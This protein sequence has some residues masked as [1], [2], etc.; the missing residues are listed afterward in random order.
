MENDGRGSEA[1]I[2]QSDRAGSRRLHIKSLFRLLPTC[3]LCVLSLVP[4][5]VTQVSS[6]SLFD[7]SQGPNASSV[8]RLWLDPP[9]PTPIPAPEEDSLEEHMRQAMST[10]AE[11]L[12]WDFTVESGSYGPEQA[13]AE[14]IRTVK[15]D[16]VCTSEQGS[17]LYFDTISVQSVSTEAPTATEASYPFPFHGYIAT[18]EIIEGDPGTYAEIFR[19]SNGDGVWFQAESWSYCSQ[20]RSPME[21]DVMPMAEAI[22]EAAASVGLGQNVPEPEHALP[23][24]TKPLFLPASGF[25][26][27]GHIGGEPH[28]LSVTE[29]YAYVAAGP[30][31]SILEITPGGETQRIGYVVLPDI[32]EGILAAEDYVYVADGAAGVWLIDT[33]SPE[34]PR[35]IS[36]VRLPKQTRA[37]ALVK[38]RDSIY[39]ASDT[40]IHRIDASAAPYV[41]RHTTTFSSPHPIV[42][43]DIRGD[44]LF[45][46]HIRTQLDVVRPGIQVFSIEA[47]GELRRLAELDMEGYS[48][49]ATIIAIEDTLYAAAGSAGLVVLDVGDPTAPTP[50]IFWPSEPGTANIRNIFLHGNTL[51]A[52]DTMSGLVRFDVSDPT[53]PRILD[54]APL[55]A[56]PVAAA[57]DEGNAYILTEDGLEIISSTGQES[58]SFLL[59]AWADRV[60]CSDTEAFLADDDRILAVSLADPAEPVVTGSLAFPSKVWNITACGGEFSQTPDSLCAVTGDCQARDCTGQ[61][62]VVDISQPDTLQPQASVDTTGFGVA[63][64]AVEDMLYVAARHD[65]LWT[66]SLAPA[67]LLEPA[68]FL[69]TAEFARNVAVND[70]TVLIA[71]RKGGLRLIDISNPTHPVELGSTL[72]PDETWCAASSEAIAV[73]GT[74][75]FGLHTYDISNPN[76]IREMGVLDTPATVANLFLDPTSQQAYLAAWFDGLRRVDISD[77]SQ[78]SETG[79]LLTPGSADDVDSN[80]EIIC[81]ADS[82]GGLFLLRDRH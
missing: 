30:E 23:K 15:P 11:E 36:A 6:A 51:L 44:T 73:V 3:V 65:G 72:P 12:G 34:H 27:V 47:Q 2:L 14:V 58:S 39:V 40:G 78:P 67:S 9:T 79:F 35:P 41:L 52:L 48:T 53:A 77:P 32:V 43:L 24:S 8:T 25:D 71:D 68:A 75:S 10:A 26:L 37:L 19:W 5:R 49:D 55:N 38:Q 61:V 70:N 80:G 16:G 28:A 45:A 46:A 82:R 56:A 62:F 33:A 1:I 4:T 63:L 76:R 66:Y 18:L 54:V 31:L 74:R 69:S 50:I 29:H 42:G 22:Y 20:V 13:H 59:P 81:L 57:A 60:V 7:L 64:A 21:M 17:D